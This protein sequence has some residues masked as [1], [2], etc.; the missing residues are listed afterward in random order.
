MPYNKDV[1][2]KPNAYRT[3]GVLGEVM[4][5]DKNKLTFN[6]VEMTTGEG[7]VYQQV[8]VMFQWLG[9]NNKWMFDKADKYKIFTLRVNELEKIVGMLKKAIVKPTEPEI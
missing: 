2:R 1:E 7:K 5:G 8:Q 3:I 6:H 9:S 4:R